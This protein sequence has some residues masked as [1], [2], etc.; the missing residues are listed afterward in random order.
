MDTVN[1]DMANFLQDAE[2][3]KLLLANTEAWLRP[4]ALEIA[5][6]MSHR[7]HSEGLASDETK[8]GSYKPSYLKMRLKHKL[9]ADPA[10]VLVLTR[11]L[12]NAWG[13]FATEK[14][15]AVGFQ[16]DTGAG[17][18]ASSLEKLEYAEKHFGKK[19]IELTADEN[20][21]V[22]QRLEE[23]INNLFLQQ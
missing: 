6:A 12:Q 4:I 13:V 2:K 3:V 15:W 19:I 11:K 21:I 9:G 7:I 5:G 14:G 23:I 1:V 17:K 8:I 18:E 16:E 10:V 20:K 22:A